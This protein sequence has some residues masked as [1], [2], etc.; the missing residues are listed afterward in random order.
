MVVSVVVVVVVVVIDNITL[1]DKVLYVGLRKVLSLIHYYWYVLL[2]ALL[3][4]TPLQCGK[5]GRGDKAQKALQPSV[6]GVGKWRGGILLPIRILGL[7]ER[8]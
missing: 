2:V 4:L 1:I 6:E 7:G 8:R 5:T 3:G